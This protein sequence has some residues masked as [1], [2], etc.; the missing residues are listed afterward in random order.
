MKLARNA[1]KHALAAGEKTVGMW[2]SINSP[3][4]TAAHAS[5][6]YDWTV[7]DMEHTPGGLDTV[8]QQLTVLEAEGVPALVRVPWN[9]TVMIKRVMDAGAQGIVVPYVQTVE[10][11]RA[12]AAATR[13]PPNGVRGFGG[14]T[15]ATKYGRVTDYLQRCEE[16]FVLILQ[17]ETQAAMD[18]AVEMGRIEG[19][20]GIFFGPADIAADIGHLGKPMADETWQAIMPAA[21][22]LMDAGIPAGTLVTNPD[23]AIDLYGKGFGFIACAIDSGLLA[24]AADTLLAK[25]RGGLG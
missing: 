11:A 12:A 8:V 16:E 2:A 3:F 10:E 22:K 1:F 5:A 23:M 4:A 7:V 17:V 15:R 24:R 25:V 20:D 6:G 19:V 14:T 13:Y 9:D 21:Q 18:Q